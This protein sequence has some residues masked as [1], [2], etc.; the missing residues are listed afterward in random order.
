MKYTCSIE[1]DLPLDLV[2]ALWSDESNFHHWQDGY[3]STDLLEGSKN[4]V[5]AKS[6]ITLLQ[7]RRKIELTETILTNELPFEKAALYEHVHMTNTQVTRFEELTQNKTL[8]TSIVEYTKFNGFIPKL[9]AKLF[10]G[11]FKKQSQKWMNQFK[12]FAQTKHLG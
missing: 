3:L 9:I 8:Y 11:M 1:I 4:T 6:R 5:G 7:G 12:V 2:S 10:P